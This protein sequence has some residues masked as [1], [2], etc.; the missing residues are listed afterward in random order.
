MK[1]A[2]PSMPMLA[3]LGGTLALLVGLVVLLLPLLVPELSRARDSV[4]GA[5]VLLLGLALVTSAERLTGSPMLVVLS[6]GLL[7]GRLGS[8]VALGRWQTLTHE[9]RQAL[10]AGERWQRSLTQLGATLQTLLSAAGS[11]LSALQPRRAAKASGK[12]WIRQEPAAPEA[13]SDTVSTPDTAAALDSGVAID[14]GAAVDTGAVVEAGAV[15]K[16]VAE[17]DAPEPEPLQASE[18]EPPSA[19]NGSDTVSVTS[20]AAIDALIEAAPPP[21]EDEAPAGSGAG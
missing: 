14:P 6:G 10:R 15:T 19:P 12:R 11:S 7:L 16:D 13:A 20:F 4:W 3:T 9:E 1:A 18:P 2:P 17:S 5:V 8:E 21:P